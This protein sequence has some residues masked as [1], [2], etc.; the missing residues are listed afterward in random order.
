MIPYHSSSTRIEIE[1]VWGFVLVPLALCTFRFLF[2][3][4]KHSSGRH[5]HYFDYMMHS[6]TRTLTRRVYVSARLQPAGLPRYLRHNGSSS[7]SSSSTASSDYSQAKTL[8]K[9]EYQVLS[10]GLKLLW[11]EY[12]AAWV[13]MPWK[14]GRNTDEPAF[15]SRV[16][17]A[18]PRALRFSERLWRDTLLVGNTI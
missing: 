8:I 14:H 13:R 16:T 15:D 10:I 11:F 9:H 17:L 12:K 7:S 18:S 4:R 5:T 2:N 3:G 1:L 6:A